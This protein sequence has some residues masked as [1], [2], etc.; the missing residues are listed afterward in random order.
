LSQILLLM[1]Q[2]ISKRPEATTEF[3]PDGA[4]AWLA[5]M[6]RVHESPSVMGAM[7]MS[8]SSMSGPTSV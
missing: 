8:R 4:A 5:V 7:V 3:T 1:F 6:S 2:I